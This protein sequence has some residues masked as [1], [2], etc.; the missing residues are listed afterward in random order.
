MPRHR[1]AVRGEAQLVR[2][3]GSWIVGKPRLYVVEYHRTLGQADRGAATARTD[4]IDGVGRSDVDRLADAGAVDAET[5]K[6]IIQPADPREQT[7]Q[8]MSLHLPCRVVDDLAVQTR[9][10]IRAGPHDVFVVGDAQ[11]VGA[12]QGVRP[13]RRPQRG[14]AVGRN[15]G[16]RDDR[17]FV[18][19]SDPEAETSCGTQGYQRSGRCENSPHSHSRP[20]TTRL[21]VNQTLLRPPGGRR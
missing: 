3:W 11:N 17:C 13:T 12:A 21:C 20:S 2:R 9:E 1:V 14:R 10:P 16:N 6:G 19:C 15:A 8:R 5:G 4:G 18:R 7:F